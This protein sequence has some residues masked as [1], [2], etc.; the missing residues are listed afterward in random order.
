MVI[1]DTNTW[2][3]VFDP[4]N[5]DHSKFAPVNDYIFS[6]KQ[7]LAWGGSGFI[8]EL[9]KA[10]RYLNLF[11]ELA[12]TGTAVRFPDN[13]I[14]REQARIE[15][16]VNDN[17]F[18]DPH[19]IALQIVSKVQVIV[20]NDKRSHHFIKMKALYPKRHPMPK[21]YS[22]RRNKKLLSRL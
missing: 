15:G 7:T 16:L 21:I 12:K 4:K 2:G 17:D 19:I 18:D 6:K 5:S 14:D 1:V 10:H 3:P 20:T 11:S 8:A 9:K 22:T 13:E